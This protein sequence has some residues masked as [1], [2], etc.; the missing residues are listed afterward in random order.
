M[1][2]RKP[3]HGSL[4]AKALIAIDL[5]N[6]AAKWAVNDQPHQSVSLRS[7]TWADSL[8]HEATAAANDDQ[9]QWRIASVNR[10]VTKLLV[11]RLMECSP[12]ADVRVIE[13]GDIP[14][15]TQVPAPDRVG[16]D[17]LL[18]CWMTAQLYPGSE[19]VVVGAGSAV[20]INFL[21]ADAVFLGGV[22][23]PGIAMQFDSLARGTD[24]LPSI[25]LP[26]AAEISAASLS[27][28]ATDTFSA[29]R[30]GIL[31]GVASAIDGL[32]QTG[33]QRLGHINPK[34]VYTGG[35]SPL[36]SRLSKHPHVLHP[37]LQLDAIGRLPINDALTSPTN[38]MQQVSHHSLF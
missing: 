7:A 36:L 25:E 12:D 21:T 2:T 3:A 38:T 9:T 18:S 15:A 13:H 11:G 22:I 34:I 29:I 30:S 37:R 28:P 31:L 14:I 5:G 17:R 23:L 27:I 33:S 10:P 26:V 6:S 19:A 24:L 4:R 35:D 32:I 8:I 1:P 20:T 16:I